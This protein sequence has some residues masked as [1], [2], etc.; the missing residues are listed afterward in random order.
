[1]ESDKKGRNRLQCTT[2]DCD[3]DQYKQ[4]SDGQEC[5]YCGCD[6]SKHLRVQARKT[7]AESTFQQD[8]TEDISSLLAIFPDVGI[9]VL[10]YWL[11]AAGGDIAAATMLIPDNQTQ[12]SSHNMGTYAAISK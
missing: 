4:P 11:N 12:H 8:V 3:C 9:E 7:K 10:Q 5:D 6:S 1:M 2:T